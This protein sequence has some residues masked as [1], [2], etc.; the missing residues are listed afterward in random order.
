MKKRIPYRQ[1]ENWLA[2]LPEWKARLEMMQEQLANIPG[3]TQKFELV[4][5]HGQGQKNEAILN[6]V[7][8]RLQLR[9]LEIPL[10]QLKVQVLEGAIR[11]LRP[12]ERK[13][14]EERYGHHLPNA[15]TMEKLGVSPRTYYERRKL[16]LER[17]YL[18]AGGENS[19][20]DLKDEALF[21][22]T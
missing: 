13:F 7:I 16:V 11:S 4:A 22:Q 6:E 8:R 2:D 1:V 15:D 20:L 19:I 5:I 14:V 17:I 9:E 12:E 10:L 3:L 18:F 21:E